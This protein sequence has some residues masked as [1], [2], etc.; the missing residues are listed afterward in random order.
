MFVNV[1]TLMCMTSSCPATSP[2]A[3]RSTHWQ[4]TLRWMRTTVNFQYRYGMTTLQAL[5]HLYAEGGVLRF[6]RGVGPA[7]IQGP[8]SR[9]G[10]TASNA[11]IVKY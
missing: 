6:Y 5:K 3:L 10:D 4:I 7:L 8:L 11:G 2:H 9:F 1:G